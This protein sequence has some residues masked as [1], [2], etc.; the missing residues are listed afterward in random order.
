MYVGHSAASPPLARSLALGGM[1]ERGRGGA[2]DGRGVGGGLPAL[3]LSFPRRLFGEFADDTD[4]CSIFIFQ[5]LVVSSQVD[6][7]LVAN[8]DTSQN[9][10]GISIRELTHPLSPAYSKLKYMLKTRY[11]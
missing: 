10:V 8:I 9:G 4:Q 6:Q 11:I 2:G 1:R 5:T 7:N 3:C